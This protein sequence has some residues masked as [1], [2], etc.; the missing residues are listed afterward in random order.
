MEYYGPH[1]IFTKA[2]QGYHRHPE[3]C[4]CCLGYYSCSQ[5]AQEKEIQDPPEPDPSPQGA[6]FHHMI[7][8]TNRNS[9]AA[10]AGNPLY[11]MATISEARIKGIVARR[12]SEAQTDWGGPDFPRNRSREAFWGMGEKKGRRKGPQSPPAAPP[13]P[14]GPS[15]LYALQG[16]PYCCRVLGKLW[17]TLLPINQ[18]VHWAHLPGLTTSLAPI[19]PDSQLSWWSRHWRAKEA[20][21]KQQLFSFFKCKQRQIL[22]PATHESFN[23]HTPT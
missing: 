13:Y 16:K 23:T 5:P 14:S 21:R 2:R 3:C 18:N 9:V 4:H 20:S 12:N 15:L 7:R 6:G 10:T 11:N 17:V 8:G 1:Y 22:L 19:I